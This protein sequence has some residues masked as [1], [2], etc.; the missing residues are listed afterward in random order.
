[1]NERLQFYLIILFY[2]MEKF[3]AIAANHLLSFDKAEEIAKM[4]KEERLA[5]NSEVLSR[6]IRSKSRRPTSCSVSAGQCRA[7]TTRLQ[8]AF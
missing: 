7:R 3:N 1:M 8:R 2:E 6:R 4:S 5:F